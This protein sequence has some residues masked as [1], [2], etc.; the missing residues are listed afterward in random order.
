LVFARR[1]RNGADTGMNPERL[2][3]YLIRV[4]DSSLA[5]HFEF[6]ENFLFCPISGHPVPFQDQ[7][8]AEHRQLNGLAAKARMVGLD[9]EELTAFSVLLTRHIRFEETVVFP[10]IEKTT[11]HDRLTDIGSCLRAFRK[12]TGPGWP[13]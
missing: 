13:G 11:G 9:S 8:T 1:M 7:I 6:E 12:P 2:N 3:E 10:W 4:W 5:T